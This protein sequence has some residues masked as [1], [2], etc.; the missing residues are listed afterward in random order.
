MSRQPVRS[1]PFFPSRLASVERATPAPRRSP[2]P[3]LRLV[4]IG[5]GCSCPGCGSEPIPL[6]ERFGYT[7][8][9]TA[10]GRPE[11]YIRGVTA[12]DA[13]RLLGMW[14]ESALEGDGFAAGDLLC[15]GPGRPTWR[16]RTVADP[17]AT[18]LWAE[19]AYGGT[20]H[21]PVRALEMV[22]V[23][24][25][26]YDPF[27]GVDEGAGV[28]DFGL[29]GSGFADFGISAGRRPGAGSSESRSSESRSLSRGRTQSPPAARPGSRSQARS[30][31]QSPSRGATGCHVTPSRST[32]ADRRWSS[33]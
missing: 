14:G 17:A 8:G 10:Y 23:P 28:A 18:L 33:R 19:H 27:C 22:R 26:R 31:S 21:G 30:Q 24:G 12:D 1:R 32:R 9:L 5:E 20:E 2:E 11:L 6:A 25:H 13:G 7:I 4:H 16:L 29:D 15:E 3:P